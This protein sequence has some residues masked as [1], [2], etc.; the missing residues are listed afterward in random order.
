MAAALVCNAPGDSKCGSGNREDRITKYLTQVVRSHR[1]LL[2][3]LNQVADLDRIRFTMP[4]AHDRIGSAARIDL[5]GGPDESVRIL[6]DA[7]CE[8]EMLSSLEPMNR[9]LMRDTR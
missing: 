5:N 2:K 4:A 3:S 9:G 8:I 6:T 1:P 7:T